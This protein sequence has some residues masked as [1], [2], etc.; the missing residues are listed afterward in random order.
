MKN[1]V[2]KLGLLAS[3]MLV[4]F[5]STTANAQFFELPYPNSDISRFRWEGVV[6]GTSFVSIRGRHVEVKTRS[7]LPVQRQQFNFTD[8]LPRAS[9]DL[10]LDAFNGRGRVRLVQYPQPGNDF[11]AVVGIDD[12]SGGRDLYGFE[13]QWFDRTWRDVGGGWSGNNPRNTDDVTWGGRVDG[14]VIIRFRGGRAWEQTVNGWGVSNVRYD[15]SAPLPEHP[16]SVNL[17][18]SQGRGEVLIIEQPTRSNDFTA[19]VLA[20]DPRGGADDY[21]FT[22]TWEKARFHDNDHGHGPGR[23]G[24]SRSTG[25]RWSGRVDGG[26]IIFIRG[27]R[28]WVSHQSGQPINNESLR[29]FQTLPAANQ[30]VA[31]RKVEGRGIVRVIE[32]PWSGNNYTAAILIED[33]DGGADRYAIDVEW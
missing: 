10:G 14:E 23:P 4:S 13:L 7:G 17:I 29:F 27:N 19:V 5:F 1:S 32:Q 6:D 18:K 16:L 26:D 21:A 9:V 3:L 22:L 11:T 33:R 28:L 15:F 24:G 31:V 20:R 25:L 30:S 2:L 8:P 12:N